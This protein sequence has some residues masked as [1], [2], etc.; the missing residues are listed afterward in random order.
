[1]EVQAL[2]N[3]YARAGYPRHIQTVCGEVLKKRPNDPVFLFWR[4]YGLIR[5]NS[6]SEALRELESLQGKREVEVA[7]IA[8]MI[9]AHKQCKIVDE[10]AISDL[11]QRLEAKEMD[12]QER[13]LV[14]AATFY[15]LQGGYIC[16]EKAK[17]MVDK[18][19]TVQ[20][21]YPQAQC[22]KGWIE[23]AL[24]D[25]DEDSVGGVDRA[26]V[27]FDQVL[28]QTASDGQKEL[29]ALLGKALCLER[30]DQHS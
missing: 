8:A 6:F 28:E 12:A 10:E 29:E 5:E 14:Q 2:V 20:P 4:S 24:E 21:N 1:M 27:I 22:L 15:W 30:K 26:N 18:V 7:T 13:T 3:Y 23:I 19:L 17:D 11:E 25:C 9:Y 16:L